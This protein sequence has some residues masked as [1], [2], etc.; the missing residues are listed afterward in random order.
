MEHCHFKNYAVIENRKTNVLHVP[1]AYEGESCENFFSY[2]ESFSCILPQ[3][4]RSPACEST[5][6]IKYVFFPIIT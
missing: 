5:L 3:I 6:P 2:K 1:T 4:K